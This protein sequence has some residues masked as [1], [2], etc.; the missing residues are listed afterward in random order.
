M[1]NNKQVSLADVLASE[2]PHTR[3]K[4]AKR[5]LYLKSEYQHTSIRKD[6]RDALN[7]VAVIILSAIGFAVIILLF[8]LKHT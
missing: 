7:S 6:V 3:D 8:Y 5:W 2:I 1:R 4:A